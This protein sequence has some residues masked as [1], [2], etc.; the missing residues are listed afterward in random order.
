MR[1]GLLWFVMYVAER[2]GGGGGGAA[3]PTACQC[4]HMKEEGGMS[5]CICG[6]AEEM[7]KG[8]KWNKM[9]EEEK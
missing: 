8:E 6:K 3:R 2:V 7:D 5:V 1:A 4:S 9:E